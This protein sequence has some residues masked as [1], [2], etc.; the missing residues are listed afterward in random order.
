MLHLWHISYSL[1]KSGKKSKF[2]K[3][4]EFQSEMYYS[5]IVKNLIDKIW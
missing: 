3:Q 2:V 4:K 5:N 1:I